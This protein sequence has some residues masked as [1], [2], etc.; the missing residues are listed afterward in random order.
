MKE[1]ARNALSRRHFLKAGVGAAALLSTFRLD[2]A[3]IKEAMSQIRE[4]GVSVLWVHG[5]ACQSCTVSLLNTTYPDVA[6]VIFGTLPEV[7]IDFDFQTVIMP[8]WGDSALEALKN[9]PKDY[10]LLVEGAIQTKNNGTFCTIGEIDGKPITMMDWIR[11]LSKD[12]MAVVAVGTCAAYGGIPAG[13]P[14]PTGAV[15][16]IDFLGVNYVSR[17]NLPIVN[18]PGCPPH[19]DWMVGTLAS[20]ILAAK[21]LY[22]FPELDSLGR[23]KMFF[24]RSV[25]DDCPRRAFYDDGTFAERF[26]HDGCIFQLGCKGP[27]SY[28]DCNSRKW[29]NGLNSCPIS[30]APCLAC[31]QPEFPD[32]S[33]PF[34]EPLPIPPL[35]MKEAA[36]IGAVVGGILAGAYWLQGRKEKRGGH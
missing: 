1:Q 2:D 30:G 33:S 10:I 25:H 16:T 13:T 7:K 32:K 8:K 27:I 12:A 36:G 4:G 14:N 20:V 6:D 24:G 5:A 34:F 29:N 23:P 15:S 3:I 35:S 9:P 21:K 18:I 11:R 31:V 17:L 19:P 26:G 22:P 28:A